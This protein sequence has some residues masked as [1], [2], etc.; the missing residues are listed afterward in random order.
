MTNNIEMQVE[1]NFYKVTLASGIRWFFK[2]DFKGF[3]NFFLGENPQYVGNPEVYEYLATG[4]SIIRWGDGETANL[5]GKSTWHQESSAELSQRLEAVLQLALKKPE[6]M[7]GPSEGILE[8]RFLD[9]RSYA[10]SYRRNCWSTRVL[11]NLPKFRGLMQR[12]AFD[13]SWF[14]KNFTQIPE[15]FRVLKITERDVLFVSSNSSKFLEKECPALHFLQIDSRN[16]FRRY[17]SLEDAV[18]RWLTEHSRDPLVVIAGGST[19]KVLISRF[20]PHAQFVDIGSGMRFLD[21]GIITYDW[22]SK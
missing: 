17:P 6:I 5:R 9:T 16:A 11:F 15:V 8:G 12:R 22:D 18:E 21:E 1:S 4:Y 2:L 3:K 20:H 14:Y 13:A 7:I 10:W 19:S